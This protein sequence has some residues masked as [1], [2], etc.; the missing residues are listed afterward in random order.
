MSAQPQLKIKYED[1]QREVCKTF[2]QGIEWLAFQI[3]A[4]HEKLT[5]RDEG[6]YG[7]LSTIQCVEIIR[8]C[9]A[10]EL[11]RTFYMEAGYIRHQAALF[12]KLVTAFEKV[13]DKAE[14]ES[15][16]WHK[17]VAEIR[18]WLERT[19]RA[20][21][22]FTETF[23]LEIAAE[24]VADGN[25]LNQDVLDQAKADITGA[26]KAGEVK[27]RYIGADAVGGIPHPGNFALRKIVAH[28]ARYLE[29]FS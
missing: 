22:L 26:L 13:E 2:S 15:D 28:P 9:K 20:Y 1:A 29:L 10:N 3:D 18:A 7:Y 17:P 14:L 27:P 8:S 25:R 12:E 16:S 5:P 6:E 24:L 23:A 21:A 4:L 19:R 11:G